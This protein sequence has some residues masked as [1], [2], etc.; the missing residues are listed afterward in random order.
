MS[1]S[2][3]IAPKGKYEL[4]DFITLDVL[5]TPKPEARTKAYVVRQG[6]RNVVRGRKFYRHRLEG[7]LT[8]A[9]G[10]KDRQNKTVQAVAPGSVFTFEVEYNDLREQELRLLL[11][12]L[13]LEPGLWHKVG[14]GK[15]I[16]MGSAHIE[17]I[18]WQ[19]IY[20]QARYQSLGG[21]MDKPLEG[22]ALQT[23]LETWLRAYRESQAPNLQDLRELWRYEH[24]YDV[25]YA[26]PGL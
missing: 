18:S 24:E 2:D 15:P 13:A 10:R 9:G 6:G 14:L 8:R 19:R 21:G 23:E 7:V 22:D 17:I 12:A 3:A 26:R 25:R 4:M 1:I 16:G 11:Y 20:R 5:S